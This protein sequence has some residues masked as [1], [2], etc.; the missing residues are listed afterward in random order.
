MD[1]RNF[2]NGRPA[3]P[4]RLRRHLRK[5]R[6]VGIFVTVVSVAIPFLTVLKILK[7]T[8]FLNIFA[9]ILIVIGPIMY[10]V[11]LA[12]DSYVDRAP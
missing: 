7:S 11:G 9:Y 8:Y 1:Y 6:P 4:P 12:Y 10:L 2:E 3:T 5:L